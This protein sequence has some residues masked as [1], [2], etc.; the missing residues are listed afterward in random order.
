MDR[1]DIRDGALWVTQNKTGKKLRIAIVSDLGAVVDHVLNRSRKATGPALIQNDAGERLTY[2]A[3]RSCFDK[4]R[5]AAGVDFQFRDLRAKA[6]SD[7]GDLEHAQ[8]LL[9]HKT[10]NM[11]EHYTREQIGE[12][13]ESLRRRIV[14]EGVEIVEDAG[15]GK[16]RK[17]A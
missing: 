15:P 10:R 12:Q 13:V 6:A 17:P 8:R 1:A 14:E 11:T 4:A 5:D 2:A 16:T 3:M 9:G 7:A